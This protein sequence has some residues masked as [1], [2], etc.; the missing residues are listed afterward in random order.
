MGK[1]ILVVEDDLSTS[2]LECELLDILDY[3]VQ[4]ARTVR[5]ALGL[6]RAVPPDAIVLDLRL[7]DADGR[8]LLE[9]LRAEPGCAEIPILI[10]S[11]AGRPAEEAALAYGA[12]FVAQPF[13]VVPFLAAVQEMEGGR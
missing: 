1:R 11:G 3:E 8:S 10:V 4:T 13:D 9:A 7:P 5:E 2:R 12:R 6:A